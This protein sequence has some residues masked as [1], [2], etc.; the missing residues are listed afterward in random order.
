MSYADNDYKFVAVLNKK[1]PSAQLY[2][3][4]GHM[5]TG[6]VSLCVEIEQMRFLQYVDADGGLHPAISHYP[7]IVLEANNSNQIRLLRQKAIQSGIL[8]NDFVQQMLAGSAEEQLRQTR[9]VREEE[10]E[11]YGICL[12]GPSE[13][14]SLLTKKFSLY[15]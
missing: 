10:L 3:A 2:N 15:K 11:Y 1:I 12:F 8:Y 9:G 14:L 4:L 5:A 13:N 7:F 6:L